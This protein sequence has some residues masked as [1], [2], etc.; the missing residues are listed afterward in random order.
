[1]AKAGQHL[2]ALCMMFSSTAG[3]GEI[4]RPGCPTTDP[5]LR[6]ARALLQGPSMFAAVGEEVVMSVHN[7]PAKAAG[8]VEGHLT[9][10]LLAT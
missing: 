3:S 2:Q 1:M 8:K 5:T 6:L 7:I 4:E 9:V 10:D